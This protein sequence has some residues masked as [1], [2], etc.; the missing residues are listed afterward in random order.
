MPVEFYKKSGEPEDPERLKSRALVY[1]KRAEAAKKENPELESLLAR[2]DFQWIKRR[3]E[4][5]LSKSGKSPEEINFLGPESVVPGRTDG[6][7]AIYRNN[8]NQIFIDLDKIK[9]VS[10]ERTLLPN[11]I[12]IIIH[13]EIHAVSRNKCAGLFERD[14]DGFLRVNI[15]S[16][17]TQLHVETGPEAFEDIAY[18]LFD[19]GVTEK[20][21]QELTV[22]YFKS[23]PDSYEYKKAQAYY[24]SDETKKSYILPTSLVDAMISKIAN[25]TGFSK[26]MVWQAIV[27]GKIE[28][29]DLS[30]PDF[31]SMFA[32]IFTP[33]FIRSLAEATEEDELRLISMIESLDLEKNDPD[34]LARIKKR[35]EVAAQIHKERLQQHKAE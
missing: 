30:D 1:R 32:E 16:G 31:E 2:I 11:I 13:E 25:E 8:A 29:E 35:I 4:T 17:Y 9:S 28:G 10:T 23:H 5:L 26:Q 6:D 24:D 21:T 14:S 7:V 27:R 3:M 19:E 20:I 12:H 33:D 15:Q 22:D 18:C 34:L